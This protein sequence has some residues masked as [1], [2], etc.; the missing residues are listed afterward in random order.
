MMRAIADAELG[1]IAMGIG[2]A[3]RASKPVTIPRPMHAPADVVRLLIAALDAPRITTRVA[4]LVAIRMLAGTV[5]SADALAPVRQAT[6]SADP[7]VRAEATTT[8]A[9]LEQ[10]QSRPSSPASIGSDFVLAASATRMAVN[11]RAAS[12]R[13]EQVEEREARELGRYRSPFTTP[14]PNVVPPFR[15][16]PPRFSRTPVLWVVGVAVIALLLAALR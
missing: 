11:E 12:A 3:E 1:R 5:E 15:R 6:Q 13:S 9:V 2:G 16:P 14:P 8:L 7:E 4:A 10:A